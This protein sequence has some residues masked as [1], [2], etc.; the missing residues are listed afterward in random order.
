[1]SIQAS[2][3]RVS[4]RGALRDVR[5]QGCNE[6]LM[7]DRTSP[8]AACTSEQKYLTLHICTKNES[9]SKEVTRHKP[10]HA[11]MCHRFSWQQLILTWIALLHIV[12]PV[13]RYIAGQEDATV[14][15]AMG[16]RGYTGSITLRMYVTVGTASFLTFQLQGR[17]YR[18]ND[19]H[20]LS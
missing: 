15:K 7:H 4:G 18:L 2:R 5:P 19:P 11:C 20:I 3:F 13:K 1:M 10:E 16:L 8:R 17:H 14:H 6:M 12:Q 9:Q